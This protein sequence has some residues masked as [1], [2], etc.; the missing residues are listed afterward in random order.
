MIEKELL[1]L[2]INKAFCDSQCKNFE[3]IFLAFFK[4]AQKKAPK[5]TIEFLQKIIDSGYISRQ[6]L[7]EKTTEINELNIQAALQQSISILAGRA[8]IQNEEACQMFLSYL[9]KTFPS[10]VKKSKTVIK[11]QK[12]FY[13]PPSD[14]KNGILNLME[15]LLFCMYADLQVNSEQILKSFVRKITKQNMTDKATSSEQ[16]LNKLFGENFVRSKL[17]IRFIQKRTA[18]IMEYLNNDKLNEYLL[19]YDDTV[20][21]ELNNDSN[22]TDLEFVCD[23]ISH[24][25]ITACRVIVGISIDYSL[26]SMDSIG[27]VY[28]TPLLSE[29]GKLDLLRLKNKDIIKINDPTV[30]KPI[31]KEKLTPYYI[32]Y[33]GARSSSVQSIF[34]RRD[35]TDKDEPLNFGQFPKL[36]ID[37]YLTDKYFALLQC[38]KVVT[39]TLQEYLLAKYDEIGSSL[40][41][42]NII[43]K[44]KMQPTDIER[45]LAMV[46]GNITIDNISLSS[47][48]DMQLMFSSFD[49]SD[50]STIFADIPDMSAEIKN[51]SLHT[52]TEK[53]NKELSFAKVKN[54][55]QT[56]NKELSEKI[57]ES[58][59]QIEKLNQQNSKLKNKVE[60]YQNQENINSE[61]RKK[62]SEKD[63]EIDD[64]KNK[65]ADLQE[66]IAQLQ[67]DG[68]SEQEN[69]I[70]EIP[71]SFF[72]DKK[73]LVIG[74]R[75]E[76]V[77]KLKELMPELKHTQN[78]TDNFINPDN[79]DFVLM[80][81]DYLNHSLFYKY[82][83]RL[84]HNKNGKVPVLYL[85]GSN[86]QN[87]KN[88]IY[89][90]YGNLK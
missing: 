44:T 65:I 12:I 33:K 59:S 70:E 72:K 60:K 75:W 89:N 26:I 58:N 48:I 85:Q 6:E 43:S 16:E 86:M 37:T 80:F 62:L 39:A 56:E 3:V 79:Y 23:N 71:D 47:E 54:K 29:L 27:M 20:P 4:N 14:S 76:I 53:G 21:P 68:T 28:D 34:H 83:T 36:I 45:F 11:H 57:A 5:P 64:Y 52:N 7:Y 66:I 17:Y 63:K 74:G 82:I 13:P 2:K 81:T 19:D 69:T 30:K 9:I 25:T 84:R 90:F 38:V 40:T 78:V 35:W 77:D 49:F 55:L 88:R 15:I 18:E 73:I 1:S 87:I 10:E 31:G 50:I 8:I 32:G 51:R 22:Y 61:L 24:R 46:R 41:K 42:S 67:S